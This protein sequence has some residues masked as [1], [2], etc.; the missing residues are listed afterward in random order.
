MQPSLVEPARLI[1]ETA[2]LLVEFP[3]TE[4]R[5]LAW[6]LVDGG[7][8]LSKG[9]DLNPLSGAGLLDAFIDDHSAQS[10]ADYKVIALMPSTHTVVR[11]HDIA[12]G[13]TEKQGL[14]A[15]TIESRKQCL[16][17]DIL[18]I[19]AAN[20]SDGEVI[21]A[22]IAHEAVAAGLS[23]LQ[24]MGI[25]PDF[26]IPAG[27]LFL[28]YKDQVIKVDLGFEQLLRGKRLVAPA[29]TALIEHFLEGREIAI[30][31]A[32]GLETAIAGCAP[33]NTVNLRSGIFA[34]KTSVMLSQKQKRLL[35]GVIAALLLVSIAIPLVQWMKFSMATDTA[36][37]A[38]LNAAETQFGKVENLK[39]AERE[40][41]KRLISERRGNSIF[42]VP[43]S[44]LFSA[45]QTTP[46]V[47]I[48]RL[49]YRQ[50][51]VVSARLS[52]VRNEE[53]NPVLVT[54]QNDGFVIT[55]TPTTDATGTAKADITVRVP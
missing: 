34:K 54:L 11:W 44:A 5:A 29:D 30:L 36:D 42:S 39:V 43:A 49:S 37:S 26:V 38:A 10:L 2:K 28:P 31:E 52:A 25:D 32:D 4:S 24:A 19:A 35:G 45:V 14:A 6:W 47:A 22:S 20:L 13:F 12:D 1:V 3:V 8:I 9:C 23:R 40:L 27:L 17:P 33:Q 41:D 50:D 48:D 18:H 53:I 21:T 15:A 16:D 51:G 55:A 46:G 7:A